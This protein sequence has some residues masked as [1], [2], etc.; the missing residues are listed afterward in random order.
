M[1][2]LTQAYAYYNESDNS[3][4]I[5]GIRNQKFPHLTFPATEN[6]RS[7]RQEVLELNKIEQGN[8]SKKKTWKH[9]DV[10]D[11]QQELDI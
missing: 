5:D 7:F 8:T 6:M 2:R 4:I 1:G 9:F 3:K 11:P 10:K